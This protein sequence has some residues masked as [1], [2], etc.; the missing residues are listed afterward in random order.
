MIE[1][2]ICHK[3]FTWNPCNCNCE[4][5]KSCD[6]EEYL[7]YKNCKCRN[8]LVDK[9]IKECSENIDGNEN[10]TLNDYKNVCNSCK[11]YVLLFVIAF[12][13]IAFLSLHIFIFIGT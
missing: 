4:S 5:N 2:G 9:L 7:D 10:G 6:V 12:L 1:K 3:G 13:I 11:I 8:K